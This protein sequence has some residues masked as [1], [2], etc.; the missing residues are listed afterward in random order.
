MIDELHTNDIEEVI[1]THVKTFISEFNLNT[2]SYQDSRF[3]EFNPKPNT[4]Y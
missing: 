4:K 2:K 1:T 3:L